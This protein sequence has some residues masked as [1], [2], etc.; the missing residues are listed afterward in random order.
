MYEINNINQVIVENRTKGSNMLEI[1]FSDYSTKKYAAGS[2]RNTHW[3]ALLQRLSSLGVEA[4]SEI[5]WVKVN[6]QARNA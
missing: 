2:L 1:N 5:A 6:K 3:Q 4:K